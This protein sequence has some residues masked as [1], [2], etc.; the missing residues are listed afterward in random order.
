MPIRINANTDP[1]SGKKVKVQLKNIIKDEEGLP[2]TFLYQVLFF[3]T[4]NTTPATG[5]SKFQK[6]LVETRD[7][8]FD[9]GGKVIDSGSL[10]YTSLFDSSGSIVPG[11]ITVQGYYA[12]F[13]QQ[14]LPGVGGTDPIATG[15]QGMLKLM[16]N[17]LQAN[18]ELP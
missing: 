10:L 7:A 15:S 8:R 2:S 13:K 1:I 5:S 12:S 18:S 17:I 11:A 6:V 14:S 4:D 3:E 16:L 9:V